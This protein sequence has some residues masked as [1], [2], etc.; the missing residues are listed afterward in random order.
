[1]QTG[2]QLRHLFVT[3]LCDCSPADPTALWDTFWPYICD[4]L[5]HQL[6]CINFPDPS[7][8]QVQD[9]GLYLIYQL[10]TRSGKDPHCCWPTM[11]QIVGD[12]GVIFGNR[13][14]AEQRLYNLEE[15]AQK[16]AESIAN[17]NPDQHTAFE[18]ITT[19]V[20]TKTGQIFFLHGSGG[21]GK[22]YLYNTLCYHLHSQGKIVLCVAS[23]GIAA[24]LL[25]GGRTAHSCF[26]IPIPCHESTICNISKNSHLAELIHMTDL[27]IW[28]EAPMQHRHIFETVDHSCYGSGD[29]SDLTTYRCSTAPSLS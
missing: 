6:E 9:Y 17:L 15:Q 5:K 21:T 8:A 2:N 19:A 26:K 14:I 18:K 20:T 24:L 11:P 23:S 22:T 16:V 4:D 25:K 7:E 1:M 27:V 13:L 10:L 28:D 29:M 12:W 3:I